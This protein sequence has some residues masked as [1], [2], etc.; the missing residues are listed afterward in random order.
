M[1]MNGRLVQIKIY[2]SS[3]KLD[4]DK[5]EEI[6]RDGFERHQNFG[7]SCRINYQNKTFFEGTVENI[8]YLIKHC[9]FLFNFS[10]KN[11]YLVNVEIKNKIWNFSYMDLLHV[12]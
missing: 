11:Y 10:L 12:S 1:V 9:L 3:I 8:F 6:L 2:R 4:T 5:I 7:K